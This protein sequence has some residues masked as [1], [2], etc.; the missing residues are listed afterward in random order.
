MSV[1]IK[2]ITSW[3]IEVE[4]KPG[5]LAQTLE[6]LA[7]AHADLAVVMGYRYPGAHEKAAIEIYPVTGK[8]TVAAAKGMGLTTSAT[9]T[10]L[11]TGDN[12]PGLGLGELSVRLRNQGRKVKRVAW[13]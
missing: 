12:K 10:L 6:P 9:P 13:G 5:I 2:P 11:V 8:K 3:R 1:K 4:N 7:A